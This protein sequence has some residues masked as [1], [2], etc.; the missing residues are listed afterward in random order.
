ME[1]LENQIQSLI[2]WGIE[3]EDIHS[4]YRQT[5]K[6]YEKLYK[7]VLKRI[8]KGMHLPKNSEYFIELDSVKKGTYNAAQVQEKIIKNHPCLKKESAAIKEYIKRK[9]ILVLRYGLKRDK[10]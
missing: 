1:S 3:R 4:W 9:N 5:D 8:K 10:K 6:E 2:Y 7:K